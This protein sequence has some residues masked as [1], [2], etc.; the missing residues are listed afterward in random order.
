MPPASQ[1]TFSGAAGEEN[2]DDVHT[3]VDIQMK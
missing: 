1:V 2:A 3:M